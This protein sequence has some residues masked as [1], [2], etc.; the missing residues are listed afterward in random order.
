MNECN[1]S[2]AHYTSTLAAY[3]SEKY[4]FTTFTGVGA[5]RDSRTGLVLL[6]HD[7][8]KSVAKALD[9]A[10][11]ET[12]LGISATYFIR[13]HSNYY[14]PFGHVCYR[15]IKEIISLGHQVGLHTEFYDAAKI[16]GEDPMEMFRREIKVIENVIDAVCPCYSLHRTSGSSTIEEIKACT[17]RIREEI[18]LPGAY[19]REF[20]AGFKYLSDSSGIWREGCFC[21]HTGKHNRLHLLTHPD[22]WFHTHI[23]LEEPLV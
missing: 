16:S 14:N 22:W 15:Q 9:M 21:G 17:S 3:L 20:Q 7:V 18:K 19:D 4:V 6:R 23:E 5:A 10:R 12:A 1:F 8:D 11:I 13:V 2:F